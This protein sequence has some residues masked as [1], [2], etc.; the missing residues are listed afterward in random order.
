[1]TEKLPIK[2][3]EKRDQDLFRV[4]GNASNPP[5]WI[6]SG[7][8]LKIKANSLIANLLSSTIAASQSNSKP[9]FIPD[10]LEIEIFEEAKAKSHKKY[11]SNFW[12]SNN[13]ITEI[14]LE[15]DNKLLVRVD[16]IDALEAVQKKLNEPER[17]AYAI[18]A[19]EKIS[20]F[21]S[22]TI[23]FEDSLNYKLKLVN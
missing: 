16:N 14:G 5:P 1:M 21:K 18:S 19:M 8:E 10:I 23:G 22:D 9:K 20:L 17:Y 11:I 3:F 4:E 2:I 13:K 12:N 6:L 7:N 15:K